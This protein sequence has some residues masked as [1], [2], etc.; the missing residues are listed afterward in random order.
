[1]LTDHEA[2]AILKAAREAGA[3][4]AGRTL[5]RLPWAVAPLFEKWLGAHFPDTKEKVLHRI[6][7]IRGGKLYDSHFGVRHRGQ[8]RYAEHLA[9]LFHVARRQAG[10]PESVP[11]LST[12]HFRKAG[13]PQLTLG[14]D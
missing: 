6:R 12:K 10:Y 13:G 7:E 14:F 5:I 1:G 3:L 4:W 8:V 9:D 11:E 2:P